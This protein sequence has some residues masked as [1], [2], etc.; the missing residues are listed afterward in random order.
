[1][2]TTIAELQDSVRRAAAAKTALRI[3][4]AGSKDFY[5]EPSGGELLD[6]GGY[7]GIV[8]YEPTELVI[9]VRAG[10]PI[11]EVEAAMAERNQFLAFEPPR[12]GGTGTIGGAVAAGLS[13]PR[14][15]HAGALRDFVLGVRIID[16]KGDDLSFGGKVIKNVA[17]FD[18]SRLMVGS[19]GTL[20]VLTEVTLKTQ[21]RP[22]A[23]A[24][25]RLAATEDAALRKV[26]EWAGKPLPVSATCFRD[27][28]LT[29][30][31]SGAEA[32]VRAAREKIGGDP[33]SDAEADW[34]GLRDQTVPFFLGADPLWRAS[35]PSTA[36]LTG[37]AG[38]GLV[39]WGGALRWIAGAVDAAQLR[40]RI[41]SLGGHLTLFRAARKS[42][43]VFHPLAPAV[44]AIH[45]R[46]KAAMDPQ[47][48]FNR[49]RMYPDL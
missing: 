29:V 12:F 47:N 4:G 46:L 42:A 16:G 2:Q 15:P 23:D 28:T 8:D 26:N 43:L 14:R 44:R 18:L 19:M 35:L 49:G 7:R 30:R 24:S 39:E 40:D 10:T 36:S 9:T 37:V 21:P 41:A 38:L 5:G 27:G 1:M 48:I 32:A 33:V 13:G 3:R 45:R 11:A 25:L 6:L 34:D 22:P 31:L 20:G 17:G